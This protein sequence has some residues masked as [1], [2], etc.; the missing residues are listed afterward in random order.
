MTLTPAAV[1][2]AAAAGYLCGSFPTGVLVA[3][4]KGVDLTRAGSGNI[5]ATNAARVLGRRLGLVVLV[6][7][8]AKG[9][10][11]VYG[12]RRLFL[13]EPGG[14][15]LVAGVALAAVLGHIFPV[16]LRFRG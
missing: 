7:D 1:A 3:R 8:A 16:W 4:A 5:G 9:F 6:I 14:A 10:G 15:W 2:L 13:D 12:A 11:P